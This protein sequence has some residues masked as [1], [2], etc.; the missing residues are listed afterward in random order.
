[1]PI[2][3]PSFRSEGMF[4]WDKINWKLLRMLIFISSFA[5]CDVVWTYFVL[6]AVELFFGSI[7]YTG[8]H[9]SITFVVTS[10]NSKWVCEAVSLLV[11]AHPSSH[12]LRTSTSKETPTPKH[13]QG[14]IPSS[15]CTQCLRREQRAVQE[16]RND[17][18]HTFVWKLKAQDDYCLFC[19]MSILGLVGVCAF[20]FICYCP[21]VRVWGKISGVRWGFKHNRSFPSHVVMDD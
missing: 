16:S 18:A 12:H 11:E 15:V 4:S 10:E 19:L 14:G 5:P 6:A 3:L 2:A 8:N 1:M 17:L 21:W 7:K 9:N 20:V 13:P